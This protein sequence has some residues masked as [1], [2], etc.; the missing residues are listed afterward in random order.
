LYTP[1]KLW[2]T[3]GM[4]NIDYLHVKTSLIHDVAT[5]RA[6]GKRISLKFECAQPVGSFKIRGIGLLCQRLIASGKR[7]LVSSSGGNAGFAVAYAGRQLSVPVTVVVPST[8]PEHTR[9]RL[10]DYGAE[11]RIHGTVWDEADVLARELAEC[12][13]AGYVSP[14][15][16]PVI[17]EGHSTIIDE[18]AADGIKPDAVVASVGGG[19]LMCGLIEGMQRHGWSDV[20]FIA[21]ETCGAESLH[22]AIEADTLVTLSEITSIAKSLGAR[23]VAQAALDWTHCHPI[24]SVVVSDQSAIRACV[25]FANQHRILVEPACGAA[26]S[27]I[28]DQYIHLERFQNVTVV[29][30][31]GVG[32]TIEQLCTWRGSHSGTAQ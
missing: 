16:H 27:L 1:R 5:S 30:C 2:G 14:F 29:V 13:S 28:Y 3:A 8:T 15:D 6:L 31:G 17:W 32:V 4:A 26:L 23:R 11:V 10:G 19:G 7:S 18:L 21:V 20:H 9:R 22:A 12:P 24:T 25:E